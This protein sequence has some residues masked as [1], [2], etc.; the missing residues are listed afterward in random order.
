MLHALAIHYARKSLPDGKGANASILQTTEQGMA[1]NVQRD[2]DWLESELGQ[3][4]GKFLLGDVVTAAD[5][6]MMCS[7]Q[8]ILAAQLGTQDKKWEKIE[9]WLKHCEATPTYK[10]A[11]RKT[12]FSVT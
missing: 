10:A 1:E 11:V 3:S 12:G 7:L 5:C 8:F 2:L 6:N 9:Q 4:K